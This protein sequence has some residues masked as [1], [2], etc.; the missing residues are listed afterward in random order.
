MAVIFSK[1][2]KVAHV[3]Y[4]CNR[5]LVCKRGRCTK[6]SCSFCLRDVILYNFYAL[7]L[8][9]IFAIFRDM[10]YFALREIVK[11][12][13]A[14]SKRMRQRAEADVNTLAQKRAHLLA[15]HD[16]VKDDVVKLMFKKTQER[17]ENG[18][19]AAMQVVNEIS[20]ALDKQHLLYQEIETITLLMD[21]MR[22]GIENALLKEAMS[23]R[24]MEKLADWQPEQSMLFLGQ[25]ALE[26]VKNCWYFF[27]LFFVFALKFFR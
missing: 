17:A 21:S 19:S 25:T 26:N 8:N 27:S 7:M 1:Y 20:S 4:T 16:R 10:V 3:D 2:A 6:S 12:E 18:P 11:S 22:I 5:Y 9:E 13:Y 24:L 23:E 15:A 14:T